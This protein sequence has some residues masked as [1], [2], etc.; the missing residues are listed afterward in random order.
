MDEFVARLDPD[1]FHSYPKV[2]ESIDT[3]Y[4]WYFSP[5]A[6]TN[7]S[8][9][10]Q[11]RDPCIAWIASSHC[12]VN[13]V[14]FQAFIHP[15][16][17]EWNTTI[18]RALIHVFDTPFVDSDARIT[19]LRALILDGPSN[20]RIAALNLFRWKNW[21]SSDSEKWH[22]LFSSPVLGVVLEQSVKSE[23]F[24]IY[25]LLRQMPQFR[26]FYDEFAQANGLDWLLLIALNSVHYSDR[27]SEN[28]VLTGILVDQIVF[29]TVNRDVQ[30]P[31]TFSYY[32]LQSISQSHNPQD[33]YGLP[34]LHSALVWAFDNS[35]NVHDSQGRAESSS[36]FAFGPL[37]MPVEVVRSFNFVNDLSDEEWEDWVTKL[38]VLMMGVSLGGLEPGP[39]QDRSRFCRDPDGLCGRI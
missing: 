37:V 29:S 15:N 39:L 11:V 35:I 24:P 17:G 27:T 18:E 20:A 6:V 16:F 12:P 9:L 8:A 33:D 32:Y 36:P 21:R 3:L 26:W 23:D 22:R 34:S 19:F 30:V 4:R 31:L 5:H 10:E 1:S 28:Y 2:I 13:G 38:K 25:S 7:L 14:Q